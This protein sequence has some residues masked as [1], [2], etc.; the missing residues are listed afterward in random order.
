[1]IASP[2]PDYDLVPPSVLPVELKANHKIGSQCGTCGLKF[3][4]N[5]SYGFLCSRPSC[6]LG[7]NR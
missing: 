3:D 2:D 1:M 4:Y 6:P 7:Y 5:Q